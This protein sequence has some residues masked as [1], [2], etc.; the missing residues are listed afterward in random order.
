M[1]SVEEWGRSVVEDDSI[2][3]H[4]KDEALA[5]SA[6]GPDGSGARKPGRARKPPTRETRETG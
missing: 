2:A 4:R 3:L 1:E 6:G 5:L